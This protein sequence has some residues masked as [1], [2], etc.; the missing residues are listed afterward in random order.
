[1][2][3]S[4]PSAGPSR[5]SAPSTP[6]RPSRTALPPSDLGSTPVKRSEGSYTSTQGIYRSVDEAVG[7]TA[8]E[9]PGMDSEYTPFR[10][11][12]RSSPLALSSATSSKAEASSSSS[13]ASGVMEKISTSRAPPAVLPKPSN[14][15]SSTQASF[16]PSTKSDSHVTTSTP[17]TAPGKTSPMTPTRTPGRTYGSPAS[18]S[19]VRAGFGASPGPGGGGDVCPTCGKKVYLMEAVSHGRPLDSRSAHAGW[20]IGPLLIGSVERRVCTGQRAK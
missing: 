18:A 10:I 9:G 15:T 3:T 6:S 1:M 8:G 14:L 12:P 19:I 17:T 4:S 13:E 16:D 7:A 2:Y 5:P 11:V 20:K